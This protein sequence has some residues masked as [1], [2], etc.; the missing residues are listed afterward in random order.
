VDG[1]EEVEAR[2][3]RLEQAEQEGLTVI[4]ASDGVM[5]AGNA[6]GS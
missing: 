1:K 5:I 3:T 4:R 6:V 2:A